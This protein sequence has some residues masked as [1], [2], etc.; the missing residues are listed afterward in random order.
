MSHLVSIFVSLLADGGHETCPE[1]WRHVSAVS[2]IANR[3]WYATRIA[4]SHPGE[5][6]DQRPG[7]GSVFTVTL[8]QAAMPHP[9]P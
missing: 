8:P 7:Q 5:Q 4:G 3:Q 2:L 9:A 6:L 1:F